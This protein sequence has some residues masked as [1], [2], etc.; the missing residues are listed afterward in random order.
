MKRDKQLIF[1]S[2][3]VCEEGGGT[4]I[5]GSKVCVITC[6]NKSFPPLN[7]CKPKT[8]HLFKSNSVNATRIQL[9]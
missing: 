7:I 8:S 2:L 6:K 5:H 1:E 4:R 9:K 3:C